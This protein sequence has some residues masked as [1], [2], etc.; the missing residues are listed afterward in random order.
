MKRVATAPDFDYNINY[1]AG[2]SSRPLTAKVYYT[3]MITTLLYFT[4][5]WLRSEF[6]DYRKIAL[7][8][9]NENFWNNNDGLVYSDKMKK[10]LPILEQTACYLT[11]KT[12]ED[13]P[14]D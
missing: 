14:R 9:Y 5:F 4:L 1:E 10:A 8:S 12:R 2:D 13:Q 7:L 11:T 6:D 3:F